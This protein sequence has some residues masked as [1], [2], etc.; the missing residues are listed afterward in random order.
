M[1]AILLRNKIP[2]SEEVKNLAGEPVRN[3]YEDFGRILDHCDQ[4]PVRRLTEWRKE[5]KNNPKIFRVL[6]KADILLVELSFY[7]TWQEAVD[8]WLNYSRAKGRRSEQKIIVYTGAIDRWLKHLGACEIE[9]LKNEDAVKKQINSSSQTIKRTFDVMQKVDIIGAMN[10]LDVPFWKGLFPQAT[11]YWMPCIVPVKAYKK[12]FKDLDHRD[13]GRFNLCVHSDL[14]LPAHARR[15]DIMSFAVYRN[16]KKKFSGIRGVTFLQRGHKKVLKPT[17]GLIQKLGC[18]DLKIATHQRDWAE[19]ASKG[20]IGLNMM[21]TRV[22]GRWQTFHAAAGVPMIASDEI[23]AQRVLFPDL[24]LSWSDLM[25]AETVAT[26]LM[27][28]QPFYERCIEIA[29]KRV[30]W[31]GPRTQKKRLMKVLN[32]E[33]PD[34]MTQENQPDGSVLVR[35]AMGEEISMMRPM[36]PAD[37]PEEQLREAVKEWGIE[38]A[39]EMGKD[40][41]VENVKERLEGKA[42]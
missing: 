14:L 25:G 10:D 27:E 2:A 1:R 38:G 13:Q 11:V 7:I 5:K 24:A 26:R 41:L 8:D 23:S 16:L 3:S 12:R 37:F 32:G 21:C 20:W 31:F 40:E 39:D 34:E 30:D 35:N 29:Q 18:K 36:D 19:I 9:K 4:F 22:Q 17:A 15:G 28:D 42:G 33:N 6:E